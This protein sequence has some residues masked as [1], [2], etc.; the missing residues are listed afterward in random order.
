MRTIL[1]AIVVAALPASIAVAQ[2]SGTVRLDQLKLDQ[3]VASDKLLP[4]KEAG[5]GNPCAGM[6]PDFVR[7]ADSCIRIGGAVRIGV[8]SSVGPR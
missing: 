5:T 2:Q 4:L 3:P 7:V 8:G 6:G 1:L